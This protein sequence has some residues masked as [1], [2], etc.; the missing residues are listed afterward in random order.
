MAAV[1][2]EEA[3]RRLMEAEDKSENTF[4]KCRICNIEVTEDNEGPTYNVCES[5]SELEKC[6]YCETVVFFN[7]GHFNQSN[8]F[9]C[10]PCAAKQ[11]AKS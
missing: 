1:T 8:T 7:R 6:E 11:W 5:C 10:V 9:A 4:E 3:E 2:K